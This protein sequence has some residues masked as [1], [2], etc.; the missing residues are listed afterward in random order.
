MLNSY[1]MTCY[2][3]SMLIPTGNVMLLSLEVREGAANTSAQPNCSPGKQV[4]ISLFPVGEQFMP[5]QK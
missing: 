2:H 3:F 5:G 1:V 4:F